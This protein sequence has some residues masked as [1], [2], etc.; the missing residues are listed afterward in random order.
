MMHHSRPEFLPAVSKL[1][2]TEPTESMGYVHD[3]AFAGICFRGDR[4][5]RTCLTALI[6]A[7]TFYGSALPA[8]DSSAQEPTDLKVELRSATG[9]NRFQLGEVIPL[10]VLISSSTPNRYL[11][12]CKMFWESCFGYPQCRYVTKWSFD[13]TP[14]TGW[15]DIGW[16]GCMQM[17]G[18]TIEVKSSDLTMEPKEYSYTL[19]NRFRFDTPGKYTVRLSITVGLDDE[20]NQIRRPL[21]AKQN[22]NFVSKTAEIDLEILPAGDEWKRSVIEQGVAAWTA[23][24]GPY[25]NPPSPEY[26]KR[27]QD[28]AA[29]CNLGTREAAIAFAGLLSRGIDVTHCLKSNANKEAAQAEMRRLLVDSNVGVRPVFFAAYA[30]LLSP[31]PAKPGEIAAVPPNVVN[32]VRETLFAS[33]KNKTPDALIPSLETVLRNPMSGYWVI[34]G[35]A[36]DLHEPFSDDV[37]R[38]AAA[39]FDRLSEETQAALLDTDWD[40]LRSPLM[41]PLVRGKAQAGNGQALVRWLELDPATAIAF[42]HQEVV[43]PEPRFSSLY[44]R[45]PDTSLPEQEQQ[46]ARNFVALS[47]PEELIRAATL[48]HRYTT[49]AT[50]P[51]VLPFIDQHLTEWPCNVQI[52]VLAYLLKVSPE[53]ARPRVEQVLHKVRPPYCPRGE[54]FPSLGYMEASPVLDAI[55]AKQVEDGTS[56]AADAVMYLGRF[57]G[58]AMKPVVWEQLSRWHTKFIESGAKQ[59]MAAPP[60]K[61]GDWELY[62]IDSSLIEAYTRAQGWTLSPEDVLNLKK[63]LGDKD[64]AGL[65]CTFSCGSQESVGPVPGNYYIYGKVND[66]V[67]PSDDRIDYLMPAG[68]YH[69]SINQYQCADLK[70]LEQ[71]LLQF[72]AG[73]TFSVAHTGSLLDGWGEWTAIG[74][75]LRTHG[76]SFRN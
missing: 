34:Q 40:H 70:S 44:L 38:M 41:L 19:T 53:D 75:F 13:V 20:T 45:L 28:E 27:Q 8:Q 46:I 3:V 63:L 11:E 69:Y 64:T 37:I 52:P 62:N 16:H 35:S 49:R 76:Y 25:T 21:D 59:H 58:A 12:P 31:A 36:Y 5:I 57:G 32:E 26:L 47:A 4:M 24:P 18:P 73:S 6:L 15:T 43:R 50:L 10:E 68:P 51:T 2:G 54:F 7:T 42:M 66:P 30:K 60:G 9:S 55:A 1:I 33:L 29:L 65:A 71:K 56:L 22:S 61:P 74:E 17:S 48:L 14:R 39:N 23:P 67:Y 72:P